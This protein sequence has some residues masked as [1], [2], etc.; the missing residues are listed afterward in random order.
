MGAHSRPVLACSLIVQ[1]YKLDCGDVS[2][3]HGTIV[4]GVHGSVGGSCDVCRDHLG[5]P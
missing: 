2:V 1:M 3:E 4:Q 5:V